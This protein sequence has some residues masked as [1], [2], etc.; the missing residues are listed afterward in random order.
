MTLRHALLAVIEGTVKKVV[1]GNP[2]TYLEVGTVDA[3]GR[4]VVQNVEAGP[5]AVRFTGGVTTDRP[6]QK[7]SGMA[8]DPKLAAQL[9]RDE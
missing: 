5:T 7:S 6:E 2:H 8:C 9:T 1:W 4:P 3:S